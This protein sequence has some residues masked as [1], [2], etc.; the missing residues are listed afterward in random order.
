MNP[1]NEH[2]FSLTFLC[3]LFAN[4]SLKKHILLKVLFS[5]KGQLL[6][7]FGQTYNIKVIINIKW[8]RTELHSKTTCVHTHTY[9]Q[10]DICTCRHTQTTIKTENT[11]GF[12]SI[13]IVTSYSYVCLSA[14]FSFEEVLAIILKYKPRMSSEWLFGKQ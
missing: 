10:T 3:G 13:D 4:S 7:F 14:P 6:N 2:L 8:T 1:L 5:Q 12:Q 11:H 9:T